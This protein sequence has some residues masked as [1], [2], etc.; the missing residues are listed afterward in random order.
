MNKEFQEKGIG[1]DNV[2]INPKVLLSERAWEK[3]IW[4]ISRWVSKEDKEAGKIYSKEEAIKLFG[5]PQFTTVRG[6]LLGVAIALREGTFFPTI[7][8]Q[9]ER[10]SIFSIFLPIVGKKV[11]SLK[12]IATP[13][14]PPRTVVN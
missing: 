5:V 12:A 3:A 9:I 14:N 1:I 8:K 2:A 13:D 4:R 10:K 7:G 6:G 11:L